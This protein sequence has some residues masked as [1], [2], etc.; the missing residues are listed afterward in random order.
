MT[1]NPPLCSNL[2]RLGHIGGSMHALG[3]QGDQHTQWGGLGPG[4]QGCPGDPKESPGR[5]GGTGTL[6]EVTL[7]LDI[8]TH[9]NF[10]KPW[11]QDP[12]GTIVQRRQD[13][14]LERSKELQRS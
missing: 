1:L 2:L 3:V 8:E 9:R 6:A 14:G 11:A 12:A 7:E 13:V 4:S 10:S 5:A